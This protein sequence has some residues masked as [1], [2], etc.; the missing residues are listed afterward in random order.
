LGFNL[1]VGPYAEHSRVV[2]RLS[3]GQETWSSH[4]GTAR[5][6]SGIAL[7][8]CSQPLTFDRTAKP[9]FPADIRAV[10]SSL[11]DI[12]QPRGHLSPT[13]H[14]GLS[15][16]VSFVYSRRFG[17]KPIRRKQRLLKY[18]MP[19]SNPF[20][21]FR[22]PGSLSMKAAVNP[23]VARLRRRSLLTVYPMSRPPSIGVNVHLGARNGLAVQ[24]TSR[25]PVL[26]RPSISHDQRVT[27]NRWGRS[28]VAS[29]RI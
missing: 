12:R 4:S 24:S 19:L 8:V 9:P 2:H 20:R 5:I 28:L 17:G 26:V 15:S 23:R 29:P 13:W 27:P 11:P 21:F 3:S 16:G 14:C 1:A 18:W 22:Q 7:P 10:H 6:L 25:K